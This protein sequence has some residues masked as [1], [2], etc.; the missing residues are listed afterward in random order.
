MRM[1]IDDSLAGAVDQG[2]SSAAPDTALSGLTV[3]ASQGQLTSDGRISSTTTGG[4]VVDA[5][6][7]IILAAVLCAVVGVLSLHPLLRCALQYCGRRIAPSAS[8][9]P[10]ADPHPPAA[11]AGLKKS[12]LRKMP[13]AVYGT[14]APGA[15]A[16][17]GAECAI[18]LGEFADGDAVR[19][20]PRCRHGF[21]VHCIDTWLSAHSSCPICRDSLLDDEG[22]S[23]TATAGEETAA[24]VSHSVTAGVLILAW[25]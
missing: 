21:H 7:G 1:L 4:F 12:V 22:A 15:P 13:V 10:T 9:A 23:A 19:L 5:H 16:A 6:T 18:C 17:G 2:S 24:W 11:G 25:E 3:A 14:E 20:L 8:A